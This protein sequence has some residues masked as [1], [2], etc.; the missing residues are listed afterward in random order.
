MS[1]QGAAAVAGSGPDALVA[2][3]GEVIAAGSQSFA[4]ASLLFDG[5]TRARA[6]LL[7]QWCRW[8]DD[9]VDGQT[10]GHGLQALTAADRRARLDALEAGTRAALAGRPP[11]EPAFEGLARVAAETGLAERWPLEHLAGFAHD[12]EPRAYADLPDLLGY[13]WGVAGV[14]GVM[15]ARV[16]GVAEADLPTLRRAQDLGL[17]FQLTNIARDVAE[18]ARNGRVYLPA[19]LLAQGGVAARPEAVADPGAREAVA[20]ATAAL[21]AAAEPYYASAREGLAALPWRSAWAVAA[22]ASVYGRIGRKVARRGAAALDARVSTGKAEKLVLLAGALG[23][24]AAS[25][26]RPARAR[27]ELWSAV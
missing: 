8:C 20:A 6:H 13:C 21:V 23:P 26:G 2:R 25:R 9:V 19:D 17:A 3:S 5:R 12:V 16:M 10:L 15:M 11:P 7:Y 14:V 27:A 1:A 24:V 22:A 4:A 18:D